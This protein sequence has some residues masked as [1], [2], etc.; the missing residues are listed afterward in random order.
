MSFV[1]I[2]VAEVLFMQLIMIYD[3]GFII[4]ITHNFAKIL[5]EYVP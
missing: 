5:I 2:Y 1:C 3:S 4:G